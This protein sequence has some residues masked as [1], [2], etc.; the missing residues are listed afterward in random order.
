MSQFHLYTQNY[1]HQ[2]YDIYIYIYIYIYI[3]IYTH[4][5]K[6]IYIY[7]YIYAQTILYMIYI[8]VYIYRLR[9]DFHTVMHGIGI[10]RQ[11]Q[12]SNLSF[13]WLRFLSHAI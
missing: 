4:Y 5:I 3:F 1:I 11:K 9:I 6:H 7:I 2:I 10:V 12:Y 13:F 8:H